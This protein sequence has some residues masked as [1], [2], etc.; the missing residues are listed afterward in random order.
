MYATHMDHYVCNI[1]VMSPGH[2]LD[3]I[4]GGDDGN[5]G[6]VGAYQE[7]ADNGYCTV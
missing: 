4:G 7:P 6:H 2:I 3:G 1:F 5:M